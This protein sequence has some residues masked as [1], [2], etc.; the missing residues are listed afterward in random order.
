MD[1]ASAGWPELDSVLLRRRLEEIE[2]LLVARYRLWKVSVG[3]FFS[4][5]IQISEIL[6]VGP[7]RPPGY[8]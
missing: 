7:G 8:Y 5:D 1:D 6:P 4:L 2:D 3:A